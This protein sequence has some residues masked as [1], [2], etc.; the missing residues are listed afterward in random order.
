VALPIAI[1]AGLFIQSA[2]AQASRM[3]AALF[4]YVLTTG[5][6]I[7]GLSWY[8]GS[9]G[10]TE[11]YIE[12]FGIEL[13][14]SVFVILMLAWYGWD[15]YHLVAAARERQA[16]KDLLSRHPRLEDNNVVQFYANGFA[17]WA[18][19][20]VALTQAPPTPEGF[21]LLDFINRYPPDAGTAMGAFFDSWQPSADETLVGLDNGWFVLTNVRLIQKDGRDSSFKHVPL[22]DVASYRIE[23][24]TMVFKMKNGEEIRFEN[25]EV[26]PGDQLLAQVISPGEG[27]P[28]EELTG[29]RQ[30]EW[31][32]P[33]PP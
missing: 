12:F 1:I 11:Q 7:Y 17:A 14:Q 3:G 32:P 8:G 27:E 4:G 9:D 29:V 22:A 26:L 19:G 15:T 31:A 2:I 23:G 5:V 6:L 16:T 33:T 18:G 25:V 28:E 24:A 30:A 13:S 20:N 21:Q 10:N